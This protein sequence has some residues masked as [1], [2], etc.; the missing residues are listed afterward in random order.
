MEGKSVLLERGQE[1]REKMQRP[2]L[3]I[4]DNN[5]NNSACSSKKKLLLTSSHIE[6][7]EEVGCAPRQNPAAN[8]RACVSA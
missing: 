5:S 6:V 1:R 3:K 7:D 4:E 8:K 2:R